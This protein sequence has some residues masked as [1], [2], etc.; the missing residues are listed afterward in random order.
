LSIVHPSG[1]SGTHSAACKRSD[2]A[3]AV[4]K[5][6]SVG[7]PPAGPVVPLASRRQP[8]ATDI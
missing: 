5:R 3:P 2:P 7:V 1:L 6:C 4:E 8:Q